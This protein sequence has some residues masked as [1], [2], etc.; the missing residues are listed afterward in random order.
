M[1]ALAAP[2]GFWL[3]SMQG[4]ARGDMKNIR[5]AGL[6]LIQQLAV[7]LMVIGFGTGQAWAQI[8]PS[9]STVEASDTPI[10][11]DQT[12]TI[13]ATIKKIGASEPQ[14]VAATTNSHI[15]SSP[16]T[17]T[18]EFPTSGNPTGTQTITFTYTR[19]GGGGDNPLITSI[20]VSRGDGSAIL[21]TPSPSLPLTLPD[22][23]TQTMTVTFD[24]AALTG[25][26]NV[27]LTIGATVASRN[28]T[29]GSV[30][31][32]S[33]VAELQPASG[34]AV[35]LSTNLGF[36]DGTTNATITKPTNS[37]GIVTAQLSSGLPGTATVTAVADPDGD[38]VTILQTAE[39][40]FGVGAPDADNSS[41]AADPMGGLIAGTN[42]SEI[43]ITLRDQFDNLVPNSD[44]RFEITGG[45]AGTNGSA[46]NLDSAGAMTND[47]GVATAVLSSSEPGTVIVSGFIGESTEPFDDVT[48]TFAEDEDTGIG[49]G[50]ALTGLVL[51]DGGTPVPFEPIF[52]TGTYQYTADLSAAGDQITVELK[53]RAAKRFVTLSV[54]GEGVQIT[55]DGN[56]PDVDWTSDPFNPD[57]GDMIVVRVYKKDGDEDFLSEYVINVIRSGDDDDD[58]DDNGDNGDGE[59]TEL[60]EQKVI[61]TFQE[62]TGA[63][64]SRRMDQIIANEPR[65]WTLDRR[66]TA[67]GVPQVS[68][69][70]SGE[71]G[72]P[73]IDLV[74][75]YGRVSEDQKWYVWSEAV[76]SRYSDSTG[77]LAKRKGSF[78]MLSLGTD[79]LVTD[80]LAVGLMGQVD[81]ASESIVD[82]SNVKGTGWLVG[83]YLTMEISPEL[84]FNARASFGASSNTASIDVFENGT[85][86]DG[87]FKTK[88][89]LVRASLK[90]KYELGTVIIYPDAEVTYMRETQNDYTV[91]EGVNTVAVQGLRAELGRFSLGGTVDL[92]FETSTSGLIL[93]AR[94]QIDWNFNRTG[95]ARN[96]ESWR[97]SMEVG[98]RTDPSNGWDGE[99]SVRYDGIGASGFNGV[100]ARASVGLRF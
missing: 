83:P 30:A 73:V 63:F 24:G 97:G 59:L 70:A 4:N 54:G 19:G 3:N 86:F 66:R 67:T 42:T 93:F 58:G 96:L 56:N 10:T 78:G 38:D 76:F 99:L 36:F 92:P 31:W 39:V 34:V 16:G 100:A 2:R 9:E 48:V 55:S 94:P 15:F 21:A 1:H 43:T 88:R 28:I 57:D 60:D 50:Q 7:V 37:Q 84:F 90:G 62:V 53:T 69:K 26:G 75:E 71:A 6:S 32:N 5:R 33:R 47:S 91:T 80:A 64:I 11:V 18:F 95:A 17:H 20:Q 77:G 40:V 35:R 65:A 8:S 45:T 25:T 79:Y 27:K 44:V 89:A 49:T 87:S 98:V 29:I 22:G 82:F 74:V 81:R 46:G 12:S 61:D 51:K 13:T 41:I 72:D 14:P 23:T 52:L 68:M 85:F